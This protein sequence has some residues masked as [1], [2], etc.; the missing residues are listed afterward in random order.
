MID[1]ASFSLTP[2]TQI[3]KQKPK[4]KSI[5]RIY[6]SFLFKCFLGS[7]FLILKFKM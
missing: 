3:R 2:W 5:E 4:K 6:F 1:T 7:S